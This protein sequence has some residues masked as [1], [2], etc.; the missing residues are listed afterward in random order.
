M[1]WFQA[2]AEDPLDGEFLIGSADWMY[3]NLQTRVEAATPIQRPEHKARLWEVLQLCLDDRRQAWQMQADGSYVKVAWRDLDAADPRAVGVH[4]RLMQ[5]AIERNAAS[6]EQ[7]GG[8]T[9][10]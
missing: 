6:R 5:S 8:S 4:A 3:R 9:R 7:G 2:G 10:G 1:F